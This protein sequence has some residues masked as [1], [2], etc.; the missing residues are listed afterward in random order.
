[1][2]KFFKYEDFNN[3]NKK[4]KKVSVAFRQLA[5]TNNIPN[6]KRQVDDFYATD[7]IAMEMLLDVMDFNHNVWEC[8]CG[9]GNLS[10]VLESRG[11]E[12]KS[13]DLIDRGYGK[14]NVD[15]FNQFDI[16]NGDII[17]NPPFRYATEFVVHCLNLVKEGNKVAMFLKIQFLEGITRYNEIYSKNN[18]KFIYVFS[19]RVMCAKNNDFKKYDSSALCYAWFIWEKG[20]TGDTIIRWLHK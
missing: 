14:G 7:P 20:Y 18:P 9:E 2:S 8:A 10:K 3:T 19:N 12:V 1:M 13:T 11:Y 4:D 6:C 16:F 17:T 15:I 5:S